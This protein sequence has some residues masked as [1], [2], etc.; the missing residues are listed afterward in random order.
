MDIREKIIAVRAKLKLTQDDLAKAVGV[1]RQTVSRWEDGFSEPELRYL[2]SISTLLGISLEEFLLLKNFDGLEVKPA[3][4][5]GGKASAPKDPSEVTTQALSDVIPEAIPKNFEENRARRIA[6]IKCVQIVLFYF[7]AICAA[8][9]ALAAFLIYVLRG[10]LAEE[11]EF[12]DEAS[13]P[14][15]AR[16]PTFFVML[17][18]VAIVLFSPYMQYQV[19]KG[20]NIPLV[21]IFAVASVNLFAALSAVLLAVNIVP[22]ASPTMAAIK[23]LYILCIYFIAVIVAFNCACTL[24]FFDCIEKTPYTPLPLNENEKYIPVAYVAGALMG[25]LGTPAVWVAGFFMRKEIK[26]R[27]PKFTDRFTRALVAGA[28]GEVTAVVLLLVFR[29]IAK[30]F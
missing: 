20:K 5:G 9:V 28:L 25:F 26:G 6:N 23:G 2:Q 27:I 10:N 14:I 17:T 21:G 22:E 15:A 12:F 11:L 24:Y 8:A 29:Y 30:S 4:D 13:D 18:S 1:T 7:T 3:S 19:K 16:L